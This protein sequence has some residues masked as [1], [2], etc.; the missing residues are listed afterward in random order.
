VEKYS[1]AEE[2][3]DAIMAP[4]HFTPDISGYKYRVSKYVILIAFQ[5][6]QW[7]HE[8]AAMFHCT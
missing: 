8:R 5:L 6:Q 4:A 3:T 1:R 7:L 2:A